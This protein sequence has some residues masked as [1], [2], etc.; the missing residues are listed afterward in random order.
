MLAVD[1]AL[2]PGPESMSR[3]LEIASSPQLAPEKLGLNPLTAVPHLTLGIANVKI[4]LPII[5]GFDFLEPIKKLLNFDYPGHFE[6]TTT[7]FLG[8]QPLELV[9]KSVYKVETASG[10]VVG[11]N[12]HNHPSLQLYHVYIW[13]RLAD[14]HKTL[15]ATNLDN[16]SILANYQ[17]A[18]PI[19]LE[20]IE[21]F[22]QAA[23]ANYNPHVT[24]GFVNDNSALGLLEGYVG[25]KFSFS[26]IGLYQLGNYCT[27]QVPLALHS[28][29]SFTLN[30]DLW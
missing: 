14:Q 27:C 5:Y 22:G 10:T 16:L 20:W 19:T 6:R 3:L 21:N 26:H 11:L 25:Q 28:L 12:F 9:V 18:D 17:N 1:I 15:N 4:K 13:S 8:S 23:Q 29:G 30:G 7:N 24:L 2:I